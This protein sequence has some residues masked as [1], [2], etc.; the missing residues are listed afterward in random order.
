ME[1]RKIKSKPE[2]YNF[3]IFQP[4]NFF[5]FLFSLIFQEPEWLDPN[6]EKSLET[7]NFFEGKF[8]LPSGEL[9]LEQ[10]LKELRTKESIEKMGDE[11][12]LNDESSEESIDLDDIDLKK[13]VHSVTQSTQNESNETSQTAQS[14]PTEEELKWEYIDPQQR[15]QGHFTDEKMETWNKK[16]LFPPNLIL[17]RVFWKGFVKLDFLISLLQ[18]ESPFNSKFATEDLSEYQQSPPIQQSSPSNQQ[19]S[20]SNQLTFLNSS[21]NSLLTASPLTKSNNEQIK[22]SGE[23]S[24]SEQN[25]KTPNTSKISITKVIDKDNMDSF[26]QFKGV[27]SI[28]PNSNKIEQITSDIDDI[29]PKEE[30]NI[31][32]KLFTSPPSGPQNSISIQ[33]LQKQEEEKQI[34]I[35]NP[36]IKISIPPKTKP[37]PPPN[38]NNNNNKNKNNNN[39]K[40]QQNNKSK[41]ESMHPPSNQSSNKNN[42]P[43]VVSNPNDKSA[44]NNNKKN[45]KKKT[46]NQK[47]DYGNLFNV[48]EPSFEESS[49]SSSTS[50]SVQEEQEIQVVEEP[51]VK[52]GWSINSSEQPKKSLKQIAKEE[53][54][55]T[56]IENAERERL[57]RLEEAERKKS[58]LVWSNN[59][60]ANS[61]LSLKQIQQM[62]EQNKKRI[63]KENAQKTKTI[64]NSTK[65]ENSFTVWGSPSTSKL[66][67]PQIM[68]APT[69]PPEKNVPAKKEEDDVGELLWGSEIKTNPNNNQIQDEFPSISSLKKKTKNK[70]PQ[71]SNPLIPF[72]VSK[73]KP[74]SKPKP[75]NIPPQDPNPTQPT[76]TPNKKKKK[77]VP[78]KF[79]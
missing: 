64:L 38:K 44:A 75:K 7:G 79:Y 63:E 5:F 11:K 2:V 77:M 62:E 72:Q 59:S 35:Q 58:M 21:A 39:K 71:Q 49:P 34:H 50:S 16:R 68:R 28:D 19:P 17:K 61:K 47:L 55:R 1:R 41:T 12:S 15:V 46:Q 3:F 27:Y 33:E 24:P 31:L 70:A 36:K 48:S 23:I 6:T 29:Q 54:E 45:S 56:K 32:Q 69:N 65:S 13:V 25:K 22:T 18:N 8:Q 52:I 4:P 30:N 14:N 73:Q 74:K 67:P 57:E 40:N 10:E 20:S 37:N 66:N 78:L 60:S 26:L 53:K 51:Q 43:V 42:S 9:S 76:K